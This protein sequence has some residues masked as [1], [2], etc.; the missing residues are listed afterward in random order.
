MSPVSRTTLLALYLLPMAASEADVFSFGGI[1]WDQTSSPDVAT[2]LGEGQT[3]GGAVFSDG[4][5]QEVTRSVDF[6]NKD[7]GFNARLSLGYLDDGGSTGARALNLPLYNDGSMMR[8]G[9]SLGWSGNRMVPNLSGPEFVVYESGEGANGERESR[10]PELFMVRV[11]NAATR[12]WTSWYHKGTRQFQP[13]GKRSAAGAYATAFDLDELGLSLGD[14]V[15]R[16]EI[17]N[18]VRS[19]TVTGASVPYAGNVLFSNR[20]NLG[21]R[22]R[23]MVPFIG[24][25][26]QNL[27]YG[28]D[29]LYV[30]CLQKPM[31]NP[32][33]ANAPAAV[34]PAPAKKLSADEARA[35][36]VVVLLATEGQVAV[37]QNRDGQ[38]IPD[39]K[40]FLNM[41]IGPG[42]SIV[43]GANSAA[44]LLLPDGAVL[45]LQPGSLVSLDHI[46]RTDVPTTPGHPPPTRF[47]IHLI[48]GAFLL[49]NQDSQGG[50]ASFELDAGRAGIRGAGGVI[51]FQ[52][53]EPL[54]GEPDESAGRARQLYF[55]LKT[56]MLVVPVE[57]PLTFVPPV[58]KKTPVFSPPEINPSN[59]PSDFAP[60]HL[61]FQNLAF[62]RNAVIPEGGDFDIGEGAL[63]HFDPDK[64]LNLLIPSND[65][66]GEEGVWGGASGNLLADMVA[67]DGTLTLDPDTMD[68]IANDPYIQKMFNLAGDGKVRLMMDGSGN[69]VFILENGTQIQGVD[70]PEVVKQLLADNPTLGDLLDLSAEGV[71]LSFGDDGGLVFQLEDGGRSIPGINGGI[72]LTLDEDGNMVF[73]PDDGVSL[74]DVLPPGIIGDTSDEQMVIKR[75]EGHEGRLRRAHAQRVSQIQTAK[76]K[77]TVQTTNQQLAAQKAKAAQQRAAREAQR[78]AQQAAQRA[79]QRRR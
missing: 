67:D 74:P 42:H 61:A 1:A 63:A 52:M 16:L 62:L 33:A 3:H 50:D 9:V 41:S 13:Y 59:L 70:A 10:G 11:R 12:Q 24:S 34:V 76:A 28:P 17:A 46:V 29:L 44:T 5:P 55:E 58:L 66:T 68:A 54:R 15:D 47:T 25:Y 2:Y 7:K 19:D 75:P 79:A 40:V 73:L 23:P 22:P 57:A 38:F 71:E 77:K 65:T 27:L 43:T 30:A 4:L 60:I 64:F 8:H 20:N 69:P 14:S 18:M 56:S 21:V 78:R 51:F 6:P 49:A 53:G 32:F 37:F 36:E 31:A 26:E 45:V 72:Q 48:R 35:E 39:G